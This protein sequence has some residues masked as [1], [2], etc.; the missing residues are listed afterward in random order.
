MSPVLQKYQ[1]SGKRIKRGLYKTKD[2]N[3]I[4]IDVNGAANIMV[5][6]MK[7]TG[8]ELLEEFQNMCSAF[9]KI[10]RKVKIK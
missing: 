10:G 3:L 7:D 1:F 9:S 4:N 8:R 2:W 5:K 6:G